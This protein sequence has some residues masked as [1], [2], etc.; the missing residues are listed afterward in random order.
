[1]RLSS[2]PTPEA[3]LARL[4]ERVLTM[5]G[6]PL[7]LAAI[8]G[9]SALLWGQVQA[10]AARDSAAAVMGQRV[11]AIETRHKDD[12]DTLRVVLREMA[13]RDA[14][15][16]AA[17]ARVRDERDAMHD[18]QIG[19]LSGAVAAAREGMARFGAQLEGVRADL[20]EIKGMLQRPAPPGPRAVDRLA[21]QGWS[22]GAR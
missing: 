21:P 3:T 22:G 10:N 14:E 1:M 7:L 13:E 11:G 12:V 5:V 4:A 20:A 15:G 6:V 17:V 9:L 8:T 2:V 18:R 16:R 19:E